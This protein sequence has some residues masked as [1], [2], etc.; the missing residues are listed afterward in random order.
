MEE[1]EK[2]WIIELAG[3]NPLFA[4]PNLTKIANSYKERHLRCWIKNNYSDA[5]NVVFGYDAETE[6]VHLRSLNSKDYR[7][8]FAD[9]HAILIGKQCQIQL[10]RDETFVT[11][12]N[13][14]PISCM[15]DVIT[16]KKLLDVL[17]IAESRTDVFWIHLTGYFMVMM[18]YKKTFDRYLRSLIWMH[19]KRL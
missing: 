11:L 10:F 15:Q 18:A 3:P 14:A 13:N 6:D 16:T 5:T 19:L 12:P 9:D 4:L 8:L 1:K 7:I 17:D 2:N